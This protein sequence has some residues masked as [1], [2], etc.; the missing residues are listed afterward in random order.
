MLSPDIYLDDF[1]IEGMDELLSKMI[2]KVQAD[3]YNECLVD[4]YKRMTALEFELY[5]Q[6]VIRRNELSNSLIKLKKK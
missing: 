2:K 5:N 3:A 4:V 6:R 1:G